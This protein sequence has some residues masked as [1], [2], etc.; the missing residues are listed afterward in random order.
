MADQNY[1]LEEDPQSDYEN[2]DFSINYDIDFTKKFLD[3]AKAY[4]VTPTKAD[5]SYIKE[6]N[7]LKKFVLPLLEQYLED[8]LSMKLHICIFANFFKNNTDPLET[9]EMHLDTRSR[10]VLQSEEVMEKLNEIFDELSQ[11]IETKLKLSSDWIYNYLIHADV[12]FLKY[13]PIKGKK[14][15]PLPSYLQ[16][17]KRLLTNIK[18]ND[19]NCIIWCVLAKMFPQKKNKTRPEPYR[20]FVKHLNTKGLKTNDHKSNIE[21]MEKNNETLSINVYLPDVK[22]NSLVAFRYSKRQKTEKNENFF[23][24]NLLLIHEQENY[25]FVLIESLD[26]LVKALHGNSHRGLNTHFV[27]RNCLLIMVKSKQKDHEILCRQLGSQVVSLPPENTI[28]KFKNIHKELPLSFYSVID[29]ESYLEPA[30]SC[31]KEPIK[32]DTDLQREYPWIK[33]AHERDHLLIEKC[34]LCSRESPCSHIRKTKS[35]GTHRPY[36]F[37]VKI[38]C[39]Y[40]NLYSFPLYLFHGEPWQLKEDFFKLFKTKCREIYEILHINRPVI[41]TPQQKIEHDNA[42]HCKYCLR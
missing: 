4:R 23:E 34:Q 5:P 30:S 20:R 33:Y 12:L 17:H 16:K 37:G 27:C 26:S 35:L 10:I 15:I 42:T 29:F 25:H 8:E 39:T 22:H 18:N 11:R 28:Y 2:T 41:M 24:V 31:E 40:E 9:R 7:K 6:F 38:V 19:E 1:E 36:A 32:N 14:Y 3:V 21:I 13:Q